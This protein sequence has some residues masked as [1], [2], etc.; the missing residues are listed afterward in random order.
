MGKT[1]HLRDICGKD[2][3]EN[4]KNH[5]IMCPKCEK[6][7]IF[8]HFSLTNDRKNTINNISANEAQNIVYRRSS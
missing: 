5:N 6:I 4:L 2:D 3:V 8:R 7:R 1:R